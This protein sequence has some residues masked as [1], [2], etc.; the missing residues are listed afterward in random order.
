[1][2]V[3]L[4]VLFAEMIAS[5]LEYLSVIFDVNF[6]ERTLPTRVQIRC[7]LALDGEIMLAIMLS[8]LYF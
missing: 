5:Q 8:C 4:R 7:I 3:R 6:L 1:M 2:I